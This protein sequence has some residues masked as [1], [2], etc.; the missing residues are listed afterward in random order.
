MKIDSEHLL[1]SQMP[2][3]EDISEIQQNKGEPFKFIMPENRK[4]LSLANSWAGSLFE[5]GKGATKHLPEWSS[6]LH[7][8][9]IQGEQELL[10]D[11]TLGLQ[12]LS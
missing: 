6:Q 9:M 8:M 5:V 2:N 10:V 3:T 7:N 12:R 1:E 4:I 11:M